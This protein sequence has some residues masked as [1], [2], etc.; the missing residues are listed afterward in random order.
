MGWEAR[1]RTSATLRVIDYAPACNSDGLAPNS[2]PYSSICAGRCDGAVRD[3]ADSSM[4]KVMSQRQWFW[5]S[6]CGG[7]II[8]GRLWLLPKR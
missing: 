8:I 5:R 4:E 3:E 1:V 2:V 7:Q 6:K